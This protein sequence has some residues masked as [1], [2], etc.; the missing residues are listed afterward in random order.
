M[1]PRYEYIDIARG[2]SMLVVINWH[3]LN[4]HNCYTEGWAMPLFFV[5]MGAFYRQEKCL[6]LLLHKKMYTLLIPYLFFSIPA[7][8]ISLINNGL[9]ATTLIIVNPYD[10]L[11]GNGWF[12]WCMLWCYIIN[13]GIYKFCKKR[14]SWVI[15]STIIVSLMGYYMNYIHIDGHRLVLP[16]YLS[17]AMTA[18]IFV[19]IG[20]LTK[21]CLFNAKKSYIY[22][23][24]NILV[25]LLLGMFLHPQPAN[26]CWNSYKESWLLLSINAVWGSFSIIYISRF[27]PRIIYYN[28]KIFFTYV[29]NSC[30]CHKSISFRR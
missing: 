6:Q 22:L 8:I 28:R 27:L 24:L 13:F 19:L 5:I 4:I 18:M 7:L 17:T 30:I 11:L 3:T 2:L 15:V 10:C 23:L 26:F 16:L 20:E 21:E 9:R 1:T 25:L 12:V 29:A 14:K